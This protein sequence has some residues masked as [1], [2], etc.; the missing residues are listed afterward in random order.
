M[1]DESPT[2]LVVHERERERE[3]GNVCWE[4]YCRRTAYERSVQLGVVQ[5]L[6]R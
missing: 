3:R 2:D 6:R 5:F 4:D 1:P